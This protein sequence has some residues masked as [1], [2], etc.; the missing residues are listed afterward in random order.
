MVGE[1]LVINTDLLRALHQGGTPR[2][3][4]AFGRISAH[5]GNG[6]TELEGAAHG[7]INPGPSQGSRECN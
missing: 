2:P 4:D 6:P 5:L 1:D 7:H 3:V